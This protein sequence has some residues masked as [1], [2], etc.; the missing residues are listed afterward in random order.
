MLISARSRD[1][2]PWRVRFRRRICI[3]HALRASGHHSRSPNISRCR[4]RLAATFSTAAH[5]DQA[6]HASCDRFCA[7]SCSGRSCGA[8]VF[9]QAASH[10]PRCGRGCPPPPVPVLWTACRLRRQ[11]SR[12]TRRQSRAPRSTTRRSAGCLSWTSFGCMKS[13]RGIIAGSCHPALPDSRRCVPS[14]KPVQFG[15]TPPRG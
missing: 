2:S 3:S 7:L 15:I 12:A 10:R 8:V 6:H 5:P 13:T 4:T 1:F 11:P 14:A 9:H